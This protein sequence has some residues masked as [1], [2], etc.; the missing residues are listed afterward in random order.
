EAYGRGRARYMYMP[1]QFPDGTIRPMSG[2]DLF[3]WIRQNPDTPPPIPSGRLTS[4]QEISIQQLNT[5]AGPKGSQ[6]WST[7]ALKGVYD[8]IKSFDNAKDRAIFA[9][10]LNRAEH[11]SDWLATMKNVLTQVETKN[12]SPE[13]QQLFV[14]LQRLAETMGRFRSSMGLP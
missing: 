9:H 10:A 11:S 12:L 14:N 7:G 4:A 3:S 2:L 8:N 5:E 13:G 6:T 1:Y